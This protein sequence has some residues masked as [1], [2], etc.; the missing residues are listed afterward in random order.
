M[1][2]MTR[3]TVKVDQRQTEVEAYDSYS[4][5]ARA[6]VALQVIQA[7][8]VVV[9]AGNGER[10]SYAGVSVDGCGFLSYARKA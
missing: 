10:V 8:R 2:T 1:R 7:A 3:Y 6:M 4:A 5:A 9:I